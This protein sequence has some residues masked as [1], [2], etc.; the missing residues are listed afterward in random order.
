M[1][2][3]FETVEKEL[4]RYGTRDEAALQLAAPVVPQHAL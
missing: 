2:W 3:V 4:G 1:Q